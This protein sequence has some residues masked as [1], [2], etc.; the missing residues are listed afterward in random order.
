MYENHKL[1]GE[2]RAKEIC[3][4]E[5]YHQGEITRKY[6]Q[7]VAKSRL[8]EDS[9]QYLLQALRRTSRSKCFVGFAIGRC[10]IGPYEKSLM[11][12]SA[13]KRIRLKANLDRHLSKLEAV[14]SSTL[15]VDGLKYLKSLGATR[16]Q[17]IQRR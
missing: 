10:L 11:N 14:D 3:L 13:Q 12:P 15:T 6:H 4:V 17:K 9:L 7:H 5:Q 8:S 16:R 1:C 2:L